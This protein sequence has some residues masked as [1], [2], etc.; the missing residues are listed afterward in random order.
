MISLVEAETSSKPRATRNSR[1]GSQPRSLRT[2]YPRFSDARVGYRYYSPNLHTWPNREPLGEREGPNVYGFL[3]NDPIVFFDRNGRDSGTITSGAPPSTWTTGENQPPVS[4]SP[5]PVTLPSSPVPRTTSTSPTQTDP[6]AGMTL[7]GTIV[8]GNNTIYTYE[9]NGQSMQV[10]VNKQTGERTY[11]NPN[12]TPPATGTTPPSTPTAPTPAAPSV[13]NPWNLDTANVPSLPETPDHG[14][15]WYCQCPYKDSSG[16]STV[17]PFKAGTATT[18]CSTV[19]PA[20]ITS[21]K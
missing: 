9:G 5:A 21:A 13:S 4:V 6:T 17:R 12:S 10:E 11:T 14:C 15:S 16:H 1:S 3:F 2:P 19:C 8:Q 7:I 20:A 18:A